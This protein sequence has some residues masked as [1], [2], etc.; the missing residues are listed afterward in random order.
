MR[1]NTRG[2]ETAPPGTRTPDPLIKSQ[3]PNPITDGPTNTYERHTPVPSRFT[4]SNAQDAALDP[5][6]RAFIEAWGSLP[7][8]VRLTVR[9]IIE[10]AS[11]KCAGKP[12]GE[13]DGARKG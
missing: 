6:L 10:S 2:N 3:L 1:H 9:T 12:E 7:E 8:Y 11:G 13:S 5:D 4:S